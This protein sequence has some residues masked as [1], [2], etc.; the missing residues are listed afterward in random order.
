MKIYETGE[1]SAP[2]VQDLL[3]VREKS[4]RATHLFLSEEEVKKIKPYVPQAVMGVA[5]L[6]VAEDETGTPVAF[7]GV[8]D[9]SLEMLFIA[10]LSPAA[11]HQEK[12]EP[13]E[14]PRL[15]PNIEQ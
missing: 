8:E 4:V 14:E 5:H 15:K 11:A 9:G 1:R 13:H 2:L 12:A 7:M 3:E 10:P 6:L